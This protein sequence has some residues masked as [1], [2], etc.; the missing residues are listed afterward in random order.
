MFLLQIP[1]RGAEF[2]R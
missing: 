2:G 1:L